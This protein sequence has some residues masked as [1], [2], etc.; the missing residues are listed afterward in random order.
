MPIIVSS[1]QVFDY[2]VDKG[3]V[4]SI[5]LR[6]RKKPITKTGVRWSRTESPEFKA[7]VCKLPEINKTKDEDIMLM[8]QYAQFSGLYHLNEWKKKLME[9]NDYNKWKEVPNTLYPYIISKKWKLDY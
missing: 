2:L 6:E 7:F 4:I 8:R 1:D 5:K 9:I 3:I